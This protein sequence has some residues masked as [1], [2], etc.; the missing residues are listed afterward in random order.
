VHGLRC[1]KQKLEVLAAM[2][3]CARTN[4]LAEHLW[5]HAEAGNAE[6]VRE[7]LAEGA[8]ID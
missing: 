2:A 1:K 8:E 4:A 7:V 3:G 5:R 6:G